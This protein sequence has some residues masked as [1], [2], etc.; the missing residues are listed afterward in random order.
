MHVWGNMPQ[1]THR[2]WHKMIK[3]QIQ[4]TNV[5]MFAKMKKK[6]TKEKPNLIYLQNEETHIDT[7]N[8][9]SSFKSGNLASKEYLKGNTFLDD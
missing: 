6:N 8:P 3:S 5:D 7:F 4:Q 2:R 1:N 9:P